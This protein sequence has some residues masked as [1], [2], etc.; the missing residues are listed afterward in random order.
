MPWTGKK[1][2]ISSRKHSNSPGTTNKNVRSTGAIQSV[3]RRASSSNMIGIPSRIGKASP[4]FWLINSCVSLQYSNVACVNG[5]TIASNILRCAAVCWVSLT[6]I[7]L[8]R[9]LHAGCI[10]SRSRSFR[11]ALPTRALPKEP[12]CLQPQNPKALKVS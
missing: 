3:K 9:H 8:P 1:M 11:A 12:V 10:Q 5:Q 7:L 2:T 4:A 6:A